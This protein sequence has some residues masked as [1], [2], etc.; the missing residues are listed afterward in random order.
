MTRPLLALC[1]VGVSRACFPGLIPG[2]GGGGGATAAA[3]CEDGWSHLGTKCYKL[4]TD[5][6]KSLGI[7]FFTT[8]CILHWIEKN[9]K[10]LCIFW[11]SKVY[12]LWSFCEVSWEAARLTCACSNSGELV[13]I[14]SAEENTLVKDTAGAT[15]NTWIGW[16]M[17]WVII[18]TMF[19]A[20]I[21]KYSQGRMISGQRTHSSG[22]MAQPGVTQ[23]G[24]RTILIMGEQMGTRWG[25]ST[26]HFSV[27]LRSLLFTI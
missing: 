14:T 24:G 6:V 25:T 13:S 3:K 5:K 27:K 23:T 20:I 8:S 19:M 26:N 11:S 18:L 12:N 22:A 17:S 2:T 15:E 4:F 10:K 1:L 21:Q 7:V 9:K 16:V